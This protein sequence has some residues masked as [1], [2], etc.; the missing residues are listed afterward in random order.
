MKINFAKAIP[1]I[2]TAAGIAGSLISTQELFNNEIGTPT[3]ITT[4]AIPAIITVGRM[5]RAIYEKGHGRNISQHIVVPAAY[6]LGVGVG[7]LAIA[8]K[9]SSAS[10][11]VYYY[12]CQNGSSAFVK[13]C[14]TLMD[15]C[16][17][18]LDPSEAWYIWGEKSSDYCV[19]YETLPK[20]LA[21]TDLCDRIIRPDQ[22]PGDVLCINAWNLRGEYAANI[23]WLQAQL[24]NKTQCNLGQDQTNRLDTLDFDVG[25][26]GFTFLTFIVLHPSVWNKEARPCGNKDNPFLSLVD[27]VPS[28]KRGKIASAFILAL[29]NT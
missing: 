11:C 27:E 15:S 28:K 3:Q 20:K 1:F 18:M 21:I 25:F 6:C 14:N 7:T 13:E 16:H 5:L 24:F 19:P 9:F 22:G 29:E 8:L 4:L 12:H 10:S 23:T 2:S 26:M 17:Q